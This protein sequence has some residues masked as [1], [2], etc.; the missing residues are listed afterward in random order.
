MRPILTPP[1]LDLVP[2]PP[3]LDLVCVLGRVLVTVSPVPTTTRFVRLFVRCSCYP[4]ILVRVLF[5]ISRFLMSFH[6]MFELLLPI[7]SLRLCVGE[8][9]G[10]KSLYSV[11]S[12]MYIYF[13]LPL[14]DNLPLYSLPDLRGQPPHRALTRS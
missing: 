13:L 14:L 11:R 2:F 9:K 5:S 8:G 7:S 6:L 12:C 3:L 1:R 10:K 4:V